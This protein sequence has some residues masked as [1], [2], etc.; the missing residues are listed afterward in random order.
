[1]PRLCYT[2]SMGIQDLRRARGIQ[3]NPVIWLLVCMLLLLTGCATPITA[4]PTGIEPP[5]LTAQPSLRQRAVATPAPI[6]PPAATATPSATQVVIL[7]TATSI[8]TVPVPLTPAAATDDEP[9]PNSPIFLLPTPTPWPTPSPTPFVDA[10]HFEAEGSFFSQTTFADG[11]LTQQQGSFTVARV[12]VDHAFGNDQQI[13]LSTR[14]DDGQ[15]ETIAVYQVGDYIAVNYGAGDWVVLSR[16]QGSG[17]VKAIQPITD[18]ATVFPTIVEQATLTGAETVAGVPT[19]R[20]QIDDAARFGPSLIQPLLSTS[21]VIRSLRLDAWL[22]AQTGVVVRYSFQMEIAGAR[23]FDAGFNE[24]LADQAVTWTYQVRTPG[25]GQVA[26]GPILW[27][28]DAP[29]PDRPP[30]AGF[31][32]GAFPVPPGSRLLSIISGT[33][34]WRAPAPVAEVTDFYR[35]V[36]TAQGWRVEGDTGYLQATKDAAAIYILLVEGSPGTASDGGSAETRV[37]VLA[38]P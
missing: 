7:P 3:R 19:L 2:A 13:T 35:R 32:P 29:A 14:R 4:Q 1:M 31:A 24:V 22:D 12:L 17:I 38:A 5:P 36:L 28:A 6:P 8:V 25:S 34:E 21:G 33:P 11:T 37:S 27:P 9:T 15:A 30:V 10:T 23:V 18:L 26:T 16:E 20:Y